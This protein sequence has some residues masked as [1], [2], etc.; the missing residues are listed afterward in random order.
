MIKKL[1][2]PKGYILFITIA[3]GLCGSL[4]ILA[5]YTTL[6]SKE[7]RV[8]KRI[9]ETKALLN[10][11][12]GI[13]ETAYP[14]LIRSEFTSDTTLVGNDVTFGNIDMGL[15]LDSELEFS[16]N[17][18]RIATVEGVSFL[19]TSTGELDSVKHK[20]TISVKPET[21]AKYMYLTDSEKAGGA[22]FSWGPPNFMTTERRDVYFSN[23]DIMDGLIQSNSNISLSS[24]LSISCSTFI[25]EI[26]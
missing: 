23:N 8:N 21:L 26:S 14:F 15:Y 25:A 20:V 1:S 17:G 12:T 24:T 19:R 2:D 9:A 5:F 4:L 22:P 11:E 7:L 3:I 6:L 10:A 13:A 18:D 16:E